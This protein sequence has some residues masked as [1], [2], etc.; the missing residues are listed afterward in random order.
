MAT[1][2]RLTVGA[3]AYSVVVEDLDDGRVRVTVDDGEPQEFDVTMAGVPGAFSLVAD[4]QPTRAYV[5]RS[6]AGFD[7]TV[8]GRRFEVQPASGAGRPRGALGQQDDPGKVSAPLAGV[9][10]EVR[11]AVGDTLEAGHTVAVVEAMK[12]Q[13]EVQIPL[14]GT[15]TVVHGVPGARIEQGELLIEY[16]PAEE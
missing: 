16:D 6:G 4:G 13:N 15:V 8:D 1:R 2:H 12:M 5:L 11:V 10:V 14:G 7:V 3:R 9:V